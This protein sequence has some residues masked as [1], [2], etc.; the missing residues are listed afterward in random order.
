MNKGHWRLV[1]DIL[2]VFWSF[3]LVD[4]FYC[5]SGTF[6]NYSLFT[7]VDSNRVVK[8]QIPQLTFKYLI[9]NIVLTVCGFKPVLTM[10]MTQEYRMIY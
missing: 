10:H 2:R 1:E 4:L 3:K 7:F 9:A 8:L 6:L 5:F